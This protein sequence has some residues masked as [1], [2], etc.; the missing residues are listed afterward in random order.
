MIAGTARTRPPGAVMKADPRATGRGLYK[1]HQK[2]YARRGRR[3]SSGL[4]NMGG[5]GSARV[6]LRAPWLQWNG[7]P[8]PCCSTCPRANSSVRLTI[9]PQDLICSPGWLIM[10]ALRVLLTALAAGS[11]AAT[12]ARK[13]CG[14]EIF[15]CVERLQR[16][17]V[18]A[19]EADRGPWARE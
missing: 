7:T 10:A 2:V 9:F 13:P 11:G 18:A 4:T 12:P 5:G 16:Q 17:P 15:V 14:P 3:G 1:A 6:V 8:R 19:D